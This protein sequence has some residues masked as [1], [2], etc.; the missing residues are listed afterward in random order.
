MCVFIQRRGIVDVA[1]SVASVNGISGG[2]WWAVR[3][4]EIILCSSTSCVR[5][6]VPALKQSGCSNRR[7]DY[8][9]KPKISS[10]CLCKQPETDSWGSQQGGV[11]GRRG[12]EGGRQP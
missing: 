10:N 7:H 9:W 12:R 1:Y 4:T 2:L 11:Y 3:F 6:C 5:L 8:C